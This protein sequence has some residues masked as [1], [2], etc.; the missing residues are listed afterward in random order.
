[1]QVPLGLI[2]VPLSAALA[3]LVLGLT[4]LRKPMVIVAAI[5]I[6]LGS[7]D[8]MLGMR[9]GQTI[10]IALNETP[11]LSAFGWIGLAVG[12]FLFVLSVRSRQWIT[13]ALVATQTALSSWAEKLAHHIERVEFPIVVDHL[14]MV[15]ALVAGVIGGLICIHALGYMKDWQH[16]HGH[17]KDRRNQFF[18]VLFLFLGAMFGLVFANSV[19][20]L[21]FFWEIT[22]LCSFLLIGYARTDEAMRSAFLA[23]KLNLVGGIA[24]TAAWIILVRSGQS[25]D[26]LQIMNAT[27]RAVLLPVTLICIAG[28][29]KSAQFPFSSWLLGAMVAPT[30]VSAMLHASTMVKAGVYIIVRFAPLLA[31]TSA[32]FVISLIGAGTFLIT[33]IAAIGQSNAK[34]VLAYSTIA[35]LGLIVT[36][37]GTGEYHAIWAAV[38]LIVFHAV[39]KALLFLT[40]GTLEHRIES[41]DIENMQGLVMRYPVLGLSMLIGIA[42]MFLAPFGLLISKWA[43]LEALIRVNPFLPIFVV[44]GSSATLFFWA[45]WM[46]KL[47]GAESGKRPGVDLTHPL[48]LTTLGLLAALVIVCCAIFPWIAGVLIDPYVV[49]VY[50]KTMVFDHEALVVMAIM[51]MLVAMLPLSFLFRGGKHFRQ[52]SPYLAGANY[53][54]PYRFAGSSGQEHAM[55][56]RNYYLAKY[57]K[58]EPLQRWGV[59]LAMA[60]IAALIITVAL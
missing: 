18:F 1:M 31:G 54:H 30:P 35:N 17:G 12:I 36:C 47:I 48:E 28:L 14:A 20:W 58:E 34:R 27:P 22:T 41:R 44:F 13:S 51:L 21:V 9:D 23:L 32:G 60:L 52:V 15:M 45:K 40:V 29:A 50:G 56:F 11:F 19:P 38:L 16:H 57:I 42:G 59:G 4:P 53:E 33:S 6:G 10:R 25:L 39:A 24:L 8:L 7:L 55:A 37:A 49:A 26:V 5:A 46:G 43:A 2:L 3:L